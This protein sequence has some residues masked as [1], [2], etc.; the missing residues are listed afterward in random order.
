MNKMK[1]VLIITVILTLSFSG[2]TL[3]QTYNY[4]LEGGFLYTTIDSDNVNELID[5]VNTAYQSLNDFYNNYDVKT[6]FDKFEEFDKATGFWV[7][8]HNDLG[9][10]KLGTNY[11][12][13]SEEIKGSLKVSGVNSDDY[14][15]ISDSGE[16]EIDGIY[17]NVEK[18]IN[19]NFAISAGV[20]SYSGE[21]KI[22]SRSE[23]YYGGTKEV[24]TNTESEDLDRDIG[25]KLGFVSNYKLSE[26]L[27]LLGKVNYRILE[28]DIENTSESIDLDGV[29]LK[30][31]L[32]Y[33]F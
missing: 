11:E 31:G 5:E 15:R 8:L 17:I 24:Y 10:Y 25:Y 2:I 9:D 7:G 28:L 13:F 33:K 23:E 21:I 29:E 6:D 18:E 32:N 4:S 22:K 27:R 19:E 26:N 3:A 12:S 16:I 20:G 14:L 30:G 1:K